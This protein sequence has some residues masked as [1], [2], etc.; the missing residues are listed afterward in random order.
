MKSFIEKLGHLNSSNQLYVLESYQTGLLVSGYHIGC[1]TGGFTIARLADKLGRKK[2]ILISMMVYITGI[3]IQITSTLSEKWYQFLIGRA[4]SGLCIGSVAV[5]APM[6]ISETSPTMIRGSCTTLYQVNI[7]IAILIGSIVVFSC[8]EMYNNNAE[9]IIPLSIGI[10]VAL[11]VCV[12]IL[13]TP[14]SARYL[15]SIGN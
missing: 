2:P 13:A 12:G 9:W 3:L 4:I 11:A 15:I 7:C 8:K 6:F 5:L 10:F 1:I 14:E